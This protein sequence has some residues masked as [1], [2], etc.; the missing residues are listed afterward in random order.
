ME[1]EVTSWGNSPGNTGKAHIISTVIAPIRSKRSLYYRE[2]M[3]EIASWQT[4][5]GKTCK[6]C[7]IMW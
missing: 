6:G 5:S 2:G 7:L 3:T 4:T 1:E